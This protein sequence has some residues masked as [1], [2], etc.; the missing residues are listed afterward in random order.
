MF[1][2]LAQSLISDGPIN[3]ILNHR[4]FRGVNNFSILR[5]RFLIFKGISGFP[6]ISM[7]EIHPS[8]YFIGIFLNQS[9]N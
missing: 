5:T 9:Q 1:V 6:K 7:W 2:D 8:G 4:V 3:V